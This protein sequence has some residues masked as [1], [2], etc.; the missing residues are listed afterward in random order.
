METYDLIQTAV[1]LCQNP[2]VASI[3]LLLVTI[4][5]IHGILNFIFCISRAAVA[6]TDD[7]NDI[8]LDNTVDKYDDCRG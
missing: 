4:G 6:R 5:L 1:S 3:I 7:T 2:I 8:D